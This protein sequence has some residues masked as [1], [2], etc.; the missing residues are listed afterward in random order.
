MRSQ[1]RTGFS[2]PTGL[3]Y[4]SLPVVMRMT[5]VSRARWPEVFE[6]IQIMEEAA[7]GQMRGVPPEDDDG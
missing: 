5:G 6:G 3:E 1:W 4:A 7:L 2:G